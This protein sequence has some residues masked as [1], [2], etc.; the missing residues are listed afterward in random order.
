MEILA[1]VYLAKQKNQREIGKEKGEPPQ[2]AGSGS[3]SFKIGIFVPDV[4]TPCRLNCGIWF[5]LFVHKWS[6]H[7]VTF[8]PNME[9]MGLE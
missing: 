7:L 5:K 9:T 4:L 1:K 6:P 8:N 2:H 3:K